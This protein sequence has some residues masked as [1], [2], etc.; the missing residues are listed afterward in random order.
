MDHVGEVELCHLHGER[1]DLTGP[2]GLDARPDRRQGEAPDAVEETAHGE[3]FSACHH[4]ATAATMLLV[5]LMA[6]WAV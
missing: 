5:V 1:L 6:A 3:H 2:Q 4:L